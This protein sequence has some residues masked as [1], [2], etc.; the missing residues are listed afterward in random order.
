MTRSNSRRK[1]KRKTPA[2][3]TKAFKD[4]N[5]SL[6]KNSKK[7]KISSTSVKE[8]NGLIESTKGWFEFL[9]KFP[10][11]ISSIVGAITTAIIVF[12]FLI[13]QQQTI[14][15]GKFSIAESLRNAGYDDIA[16]ARQLASRISAIIR[17]TTTHKNHRSVYSFENEPTIQVESSSTSLKSFTD[18]VDRLRAKRRYIVTGEVMALGGKLLSIKVRIEDSPEIASVKSLREIDLAINEAAEYVVEKAEPYIFAAYLLTRGEEKKS[19]DMIHFCLSNP[20]PEDDR[21]AYNLWGVYFLERGKYNLAIDKFRRAIELDPKFGIAFFN[22]AVALNSAG[23]QDESLQAFQKSVAHWPTALS[24]GGEGELLYQLGRYEQSINVL[25]MATA[26]DPHDRRLQIDLAYAYYRAGDTI[27][28]HSHAE[29]AQ[30]LDFNQFDIDL[31]RRLAVVL[32]GI[33]LVEHALNAYKRIAERD[34]NDKL[35]KLRVQILT[36]QTGKSHESLK[37]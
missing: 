6:K 4:G 24:L 19:L 15:I 25:N 17:T 28:A 7:A 3:S 18:L 9:Q 26:K 33:G 10:V 23:K 8:Q 36:K 31:E 32:D 27:S 12:I 20:P 1:S 29:L 16:I 14:V 5:I 37:K 35:A 13:G 2:H 21:W 22:L 30:D 34:P 11:V